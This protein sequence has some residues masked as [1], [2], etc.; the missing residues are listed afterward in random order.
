MKKV[1]L[2]GVPIRVLDEDG[3]IELSVKREAQ[4]RFYT[5]LRQNG[6]SFAGPQY[7][8]RKNVGKL[9][10]WLPKGSRLKGTPVTIVISIT[11]SLA[12]VFHYEAFIELWDY[13]TYLLDA[14]WQ[15]ESLI[16]N[17]SWDRYGD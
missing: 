4:P 10:F 3:I 11:E 17:A 15:L 8:F 16:T 6:F 9:D 13:K 12:R 1:R 5:T 7:T 2:E 14:W